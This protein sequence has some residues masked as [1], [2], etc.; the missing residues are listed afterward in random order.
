MTVNQCQNENVFSS[1]AS[2]GEG[3]GT[4]FPQGFL[5]HC[6]QL[7]S[8][9]L[10]RATQIARHASVSAELYVNVTVT[11]N[12]CCCDSVNDCHKSVAISGILS[13]CGA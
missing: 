2:M 8:S 5:D 10:H 11:L 4:L 13:V 1:L 9:V 7:H 3:S 6:C 12:I